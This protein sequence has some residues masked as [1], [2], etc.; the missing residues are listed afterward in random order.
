[1]RR[2]IKLVAN[3]GRNDYEGRV[4]ID[5]ELIQS[6]ITWSDMIRRCYDTK[7]HKKNPTYKDCS[8]C[9]EWLSF[10]NFKEWHDQNYST[11][12]DK[13]LATRLELDKDLLVEGN[14]IYSPETCVFIPHKVNVFLANKR[15]NNQSGYLGVCWDAGA[16]KWK[17][18]I[19]DFETHKK[20]YLGVF[21]DIEDAKKAYQLARTVEAEKAKKYLRDLGY[22][23]NVVSKVR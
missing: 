16:K 15:S 4:R 18:Q 10:K 17:A 22:A 6:Y 3:V 2:K 23:E 21:A 7:F 19:K 11:G 20:K 5:G 9:E 13:S 14:K 1:M 12:L 8:V